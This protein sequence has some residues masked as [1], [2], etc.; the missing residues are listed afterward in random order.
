VERSVGALRGVQSLTIA[1]EVFQKNLFEEDNT[2]TVQTTCEE[3]QARLNFVKASMFGVSR[4]R[5]NARAAELH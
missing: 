2:S 5:K 1:L 3:K 4:G